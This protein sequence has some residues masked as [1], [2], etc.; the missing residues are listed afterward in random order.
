MSD[1]HS[2]V[3]KQMLQD[4]L[5]AHLDHEKH[6]VDGHNSGN[7]RNGSFTKKIIAVR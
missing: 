4:E 5:D 7:S 2:Q 3:L 1:L 6:S